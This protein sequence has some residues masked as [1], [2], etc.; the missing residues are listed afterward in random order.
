MD[1]AIVHCTRGVGIWEWASNDDEDEPDVVLACCGDMPTLETLAAAAIL[2]ERLPELKVRVVNVVDLMR[3]QPESEHPHGLSDS[4]VR[5]AL[6][7]RPPGRLRVP[8]LSVADPPAHVP[9]HEPRQPAR[10]RLQGGGHDDD[11][12][13]HGDAERPRPLPSRHRRDR[14][15][16]RRSASAPRTS[17]RRWRTRACAR[18]RT[19][20][21]TARTTRRSATGPG[22]ARVSSILVVNAGS[23]SLKLSIVDGDDTS[24]PVDSL[25][26]AQVERGRAP[27]RARR[28][29][30]RRAGRRRRRRA[31]RAR[32]ARRAGAAPQRGRRSPRSTR[33]CS[34]LPDVPHV[35]VFD[36]AFHRTMPEEASTYA[37]PR[38]L[39]RRL[40]HPPLRVPRALGAVGGRAGARRR[41]SSSAISAAAAR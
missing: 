6:H 8:R 37:L 31:G 30:L 16:A 14:P 21:S 35:A 18:A 24:R 12:V 26:D 40:G 39:A 23:T 4:R 1:D 10:A 38:A 5:R 15:R 3:L 28:R 29:A 27:G 13:R 2:R 11:A 33:R 34:A 19:R 32:R 9:P 7:D 41:G 36:T 20:A 25:A 17:G 22:R